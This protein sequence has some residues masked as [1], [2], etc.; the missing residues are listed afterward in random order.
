MVRD[1]IGDCDL[2]FLT[3]T[4]ESLERAVLLISRYF[5]IFSFRHNMSWYGGVGGSGA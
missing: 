3:K 5:W 1:V 2:V 4:Q